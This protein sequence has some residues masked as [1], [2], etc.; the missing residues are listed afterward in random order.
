MYIFAH[1][2][3]KKIFKNRSLIY[4]GDLIDIIESRRCCGDRSRQMRYMEVAFA[5][6]PAT[7]VMN[8]D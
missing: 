2:V 1:M 5:L 8:I 3:Y 6:W 4:V 7:A